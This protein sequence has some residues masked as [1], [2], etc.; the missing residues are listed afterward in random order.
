[1]VKRLFLLLALTFLN[2][3]LLRA[4][5]Y[6]QYNHPELEWHSFD[7]EHF[8][9]HYHQGTELTA[10]KAAKIIEE[11][12]PAV[13]ATYNF[14]PKDRI[15]LILRDTD[16]YSNGGAFFFNNKIEIW[17]TNLDYVMRGTKNWLRDVLTHEFTHMVNIQKI[18]K[19]NMTFPYGFIQW[20]GYEKERRRDVVRGFP[21]VLV[22]Y[23]VSSVNMPVWFAEGTAQHQNDKARFDYRDPHREMILRD[24]VLHNRLL[25]LNEMSVFGKTSHGNESSYNQG[26]AFVNFLVEQYGEKVLAD[27]TEIDSHW[28]SYTF[29]GAIE[30]ATGTPVDSLYRRWK[31]QLTRRYTRQTATIRAH[32]HKGCLIE[33]EGFAN[34]YPVFDPE[35]KYV[36]WISNKGRDYFSQNRIIIWDRE[37][38]SKK[39]LPVS[40]VSSSLDWSPDGR[41]LVYA[42]QDR[43]RHMSSLNDLYLW[44]VK[45]EKEIRLSYG[46]RGSNPAFSPDGR[47]IAFVSATDGLHALNLLRL[48]QNPESETWREAAYNVTTGR[49]L[50]HKAE[51]IYQRDVRVRAS[52]LTQL[53][54]FEDGR[55]IYHPRWRPDGRRIVFGTAVEYGRNIGQ[56]DLDTGKFSILMKAREELR[57]PVY[58]PDGAWLYFSSSKTGIYNLYRV[59]SDGGPAQLLTNVTGGAFMPTVNNRG[60]VAY[61]CYDSIGYKLAFMARP[62]ALD[63]SLARYDDNY[64][65]SVPVKNFNDDTIPE[66]ATRPYKT[67]FTPTQILP[68]L[69]IDYGTVKPGFYI[70]SSDVLDQFSLVA[71]A[72][73]NR[74]FDYDLYA[75][76][77]YKKMAPTFFAE[78]YNS[79]ANI[80]DT[81]ELDRGYVVKGVRNVGFNLM[82][83]SFGVSY[84][85][86]EK[87]H[88]SLTYTGSRYSAQL[89]PLTLSTPT[90]GLLYVPTIRYDY[91]RGQAV[92][93]KFIL[94]RLG[95]DRYA[96]VNPSSGY[97]LFFKYGY[98]DNDFLQGFAT[99]RQLGLEEFKRYA[100]NSL[101]FNGELYLANPWLEQHALGLSLKSGY[102][103]RPVAGFFNYFAGGL[104]GLKGYP[105]YSIEGRQK[106]IGA[107]NYRFPI[108]RGL[109]WRLGHLRFD[110]LFAG[111]FFEAG[112]AF[113]ETRVNVA[114][115]KRDVGVELR[116]DTFSY[117][118]FP[119]RI[120]AQA[121]WPLDVAR[122]GS[123]SYPREWRYYM[124]ILFDFDLRERAGSM[125]DNTSFRSRLR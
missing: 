76:A 11:I 86:L 80:K 84:I 59:K 104:I 52:E 63:A 44:D 36:A 120:F 70:T 121:A 65:Q 43:N 51:T 26:F 75:Y 29:D 88:V 89:D 99:N 4:Q 122:N 56:Y 18:I 73:A 46:L 77:E 112:N 113:N 12:Y 7:T 96:A 21:N 92:H 101:E 62:V 61:A 39:E 3:G 50:P 67:T 91:L 19:S 111:F 32:E 82:Q 55:Q 81:L 23:P 95:N 93:F 15:H 20:F 31:Q 71:G 34:L 100:F 9:V 22:S 38:G 30:K 68:R 35:G 85:P 1:M 25:T 28:S 45:D 41:Y 60:E 74:D 5:L 27:I 49:L 58:S 114:D 48:P 6:D 98:E 40:G 90:D 117:N 83:Y 13:T 57:Y 109:N 10:F 110:K 53:L 72:A 64:P 107:L 124:G 24:R 103:D 106:L 69:F 115:F 118:M 79:S 47:S 66:Y 16:D 78:F 37:Q 54:A 17:A 108:S 125:K 105:F 87:M 8:T 2:A 33:K 42:R 119:T 97:Y 116:L 102:I 123:V 94:D 14:K